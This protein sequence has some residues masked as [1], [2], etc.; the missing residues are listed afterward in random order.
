M[1]NYRPLKNSWITV[2]GETEY[3]A[4]SNGSILI[5]SENSKIFLHWTNENGKL[6]STYTL[7]YATLVQNKL[8]I[9]S[10]ESARIQVID[11]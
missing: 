6:V 7:T 5:P 10:K 4:G 8:K 9:V 2:K 11:L 1:T 3:T